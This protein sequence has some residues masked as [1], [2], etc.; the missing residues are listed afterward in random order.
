MVKVTDQ[1]QLQIIRLVFI[2][3]CKISRKCAYKY[4]FKLRLPN[5][6]TIK[7]EHSVVQQLP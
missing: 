6:T 7:T 3:S 5:L 1:E 4:N 2:E